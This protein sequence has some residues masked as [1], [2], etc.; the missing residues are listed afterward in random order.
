M[1]FLCAAIA[2]PR[3]LFPTS[4]F[5]MVTQPTGEVMPKAASAAEI[6]CCATGRGFP[7][8]ALTFT[9]LF[10]YHVLNGVMGG[11]ATIDPIGDAHTTPGT[12]S[13]QC[14]LSGTI[15]MR[16]GGC[17]N[18][19]GWYNA[20]VPATK[21]T[22][23]YPLVPGDLTMAYPNGISCA[24]NDF[25]PLATRTTTQ[26]QNKWA[27]PLPEFAG[28]IRTD[29]KWTGGQIGFAM[30][31][32]AG[33]Q[34]PQTKYSQA[35]LNDKN[36]A[37]QQWVSTLIYQSVADPNAYYIAF[38]DQPTCA[39]SW[40]GCQPG[41]GTA[42]TDP[43]Q[44]NDGDFNDFVFYVSGISCKD[45]GMPCTVPGQMGICAG[46][47]TECASGG[48]AT[49]CRQA[50]KP[51]TEICD[52][53]DNDCNGM[54]DEGDL[55]PGGSICDKGVC[56]HAC[57]EGEF[58]CIIGLTCAPD[59]YCKDPRCVSVACGAG[60][61]CVAGICRGGCDGVTCPHGQL[62]RIGR[63]VE[64]CD[65]VTCDAGKIC[66]DGACQPPC[67][68]CRDCRAGSGRTCS[69][70]AP[71]KGVCVET[72]CEAKTCP[73][74]Q[75]CVAGTCQDGCQGVVCPGGQQC[76]GG[77]CVAVPTPDAGVGTGG[78]LGTGS[79]GSGSGGLRGTGGSG[80]GL[81]NG[82]DAGV[83]SGG[84]SGET[85][86]PAVRTCGCE[87]NGRSPRVLS[88]LSVALFVWIARRRRSR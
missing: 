13:P 4:A 51:Q 86:A 32:L 25:C 9:G 75:V 69:K 65:G 36:A 42:I 87:V 68:E 66:E 27:D 52:S 7:A 56:V 62:C 50:V 10:K 22:Q 3:A 71:N 81:S 60:Q 84:S 11:D 28:N 35:E 55:C 78:M 79:G 8:E 53:V 34:C 16:G 38:E 44:G 21:P 61:V 59:G 74:G 72:G 67:G 73:S 70:S 46:G 5:A 88:A 15:V 58:K 24:T 48:M 23:I 43:N 82:Q 1:L 47:V 19:L 12:F 20:T 29:P 18:A 49:T 40:K 37:G 31:G 6:S 63:C 54:V 2:L 14:G 39:A 26:P 57:D 45:G 30:I 33:S 77:E 80:F 17:K 85:P 76:M 41:S 83:G 64:P